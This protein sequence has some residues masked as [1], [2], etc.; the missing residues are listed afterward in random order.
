[1]TRGSPPTARVVHVLDLL[2]SSDRGLSAAE[3]ARTLGITSSTSAT[4]LA[5]L[6]AADYVE[7][8]EDKTYRLGPGL[9]GVAQAVQD[10]F[11][12][13]VA[14]HEELQGLAHDLACGVTLTCIGSDHLRVVAAVG[15]KDQVPLG[16]APGD[17]FPRTPPYG[18]IAMAW[19]PRAE[20]DTWLRGWPPSAS[21]SARAHERA[22]MEDIRATGIGVWSLEAHAVP[23]VRQIR[24]I[25]AE[26]VGDPSSQKLRAQLTTLFALFGRHGYT[27]QELQ[28]QTPRAVGYALAPVF[29]PDGSPRYQ[30]DLHLLRPSMTSRQIAHMCR[31]LTW[32][33][34]TLTA[35]ISGRP[36]A[37][38]G[39]GG[40]VGEPRRRAG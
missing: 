11:P 27:S 30:L 36:P 33:A 28:M 6:D 38:L 26:H 19:R 21:A 39:W 2:A 12:L 32:S 25:I 14:G 3:V 34:Q 1:V 20:V 10:R 24:A 9:L 31:R 29:G 17:R 22:V 15:H 5:A 18:A 40:N 4:L 13:L 16:V 8:A 7:R 23:A 37:V 35:A